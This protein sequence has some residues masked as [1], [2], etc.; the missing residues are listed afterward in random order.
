MQYNFPRDMH[1]RDKQR[2]RGAYTPH[3]V[4]QLPKT[5]A[6]AVVVQYVPEITVRKKAHLPSL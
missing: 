3:T 2:P 5:T 1:V 6:R 4:V